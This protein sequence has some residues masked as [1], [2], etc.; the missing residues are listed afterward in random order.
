[1]SKDLI[2]K[3][4]A[5]ITASY[6]LTANEQRLIL[7]AIS[8]IPKSVMVKDDEVYTVEIGDFI[9]LGVH[10]KTAYREMREAAE[11]L[12][13]RS[14]I[15]KSGDDVIKTRWVQDMGVG[16]GEGLINLAKSFGIKPT[17]MPSNQHFVVLRFSKSILP[18]LSNLSANFTQYLK[19]DIAGL[20]SSYS[21]RFYELIMQ[22]KDTGFRK[23]T[24]DDLRELLDLSNK[25]PATKDLKVRVIE[26]AVNEIN[27]K[28]KLNVEYKLI[29][30]GKKFTHLE[31]KFKI[32][33]Q[34][35]K[36]VQPI[37]KTIDMFES[38]ETN[39]QTPS[40]QVKGL[41]DAQINKLA[42]FKKEFLDANNNL[43]ASN[44]SRSYDEVFNSW[45]VLLK[46]PNSIGKFKKIQE[47]LE[48]S[49]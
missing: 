45:R 33:A 10:R 29:K 30:T 37:G 23:I 38:A 15:L 13:E 26:T 14:V 7:S 21:I 12:Y 9:E 1:M 46:D 36:N 41:S 4:N 35:E 25:Y 32:K 2:V 49:W 47:I 19:E 48:R 24:I 39:N 42:K 28:T 20:G 22:F 11:R 27:E 3:S 34:A 44:D 5:V 6:H 8:Q 31:L 40:W 16:T 43:L 18:Y 17:K